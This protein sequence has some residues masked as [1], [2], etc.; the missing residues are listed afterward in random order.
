MKYAVYVRV[1]TDK[2]E[3]VSSIQN[4]IEICR[5]WIEKNGFEWDENSIY[6]DE[7]VSGTAWL[8]RRAMQLIL[9]KARKKELD[10]V[11]FKSIHRLG[12]DLRDALEIKEILLG[13]GV[14]LVT[15]EEGYDSYYEG[16]N[17][18]K[19]EMYAMF[20]SQLPKTLS[21]SISAALAA[22]V[23]RGEYT[24]GTVPYGY[25]IVDKKYVI[26][27]EE[28]EIVREMYELYDNGLGYLRISNALN[29]VGKY[30]RSGKLWTY[31][32]VKL[33][34]TN[35]M[36]KGDYVMGRSTEVK[37]DG[38]KKRIQEPREKWVVFENHHPAI[39]ERPLWDKINNPKI[40][41]KIKRR[42]AVTNELRGI[43][44]CIHCGSPF[45]LHTYKYKNKEGEELNYGYLTCG[46]YK[47]TGGR[48]CVKHSGLRY[49]R[50]RSLVL[51][52][53]KEKERDLEKVFK[54]NDKDKHQEKQKKLRKEKKELEIKRERLLDLYLDGGSIDKE[55]FTK[56][57][58]N[59]AKNIK[60][61][62]LEILKLD[63]V[64]ALI[65]EQQ[66]VKD[67]FKLLEDS[68]NLYPVFKKLIARIDIS[69]NG[70]VD[71]RYRFEE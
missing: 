36:Y 11:V 20:A 70:A 48:G 24:G 41:K 58:A 12:R 44:R 68:E 6:K 47:L 9:G 18:L 32:A 25:R 30:K 60:E 63:D 14:R 38:R 3:Q 35:P 23:R 66:K 55:T 49:E 1:S 31:S 4:Q 19:F 27:Q 2:D 67:A 8:E 33:I 51:R 59:F 13:H 40:N 7:A 43:A 26:N 10:T 50:L 61:K 29:D 46:T 45:V 71:I 16:K 28:A 21:V 17:D 39:I 22:K 15:I 5:Y 69:Q 65:V 54:L 53:L 57:D 34:I 56:R 42:V 62:E 64:K 52:K 37:V